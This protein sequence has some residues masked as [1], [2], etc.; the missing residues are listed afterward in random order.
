MITNNVAILTS[1]DSDEPVQPPLKLRNS[2]CCSISSLTDQQQYSK[3]CLKWPLKIRLNIGFQDQSLLNA[4][5][6]YCRM[7]SWSILQYFRP[8]LSYHL[9]FDT[10]VLSFLSGHF[11]QVSLYAPPPSVRKAADINIH[12]CT[13]KHLLMCSFYCHSRLLL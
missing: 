12:L 1:V 13:H 11:R 9:S 10:F 2:K 4:G 8:S 3:T 6:K 7:L 5:Q